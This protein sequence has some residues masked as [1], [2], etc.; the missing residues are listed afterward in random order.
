MSAEGSAYRFWRRGGDGRWT[1][2]AGDDV[3]AMRTLPP[4][5]AVTP[6]TVCRRSGRADAILPFRASGRNEPYSLVLGSSQWTIVVR[7]DPLN[8]VAFAAAP[9]SR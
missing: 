8:R 6:A 9:D 5:F 2:F 4:G 3:L 7:G 1:P